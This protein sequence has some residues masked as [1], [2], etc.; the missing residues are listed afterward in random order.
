MM[1][2]VWKNVM[3]AG[4]AGF[5]AMSPVQAE[6]PATFGYSAVMAG[7]TDYMFR[8]VSFTQGEPMINA[9]VEFTYGIAYLALSAENINSGSP[10][11]IGYG[12]LGPWEQ[13]I[14]IGIRPTTGAIQW[15]IGLL[16]YIYG[17]RGGGVG[18]W[19][20]DFF[21]LK[22]GM[23][24]SPTENLTIGAT[25][26]YAP[27]Q[28]LAL[29]EGLTLQGDVSYKLKN[30]GVFTPTLSA[31]VGR[32]GLAENAHYVGGYFVDVDGDP[33]KSIVYW[34]A[35]LRLDVERLFFDFRYWDTNISSSDT[36]ARFVFSAGIDLSP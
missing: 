6:Q 19:D 31:T 15:D 27:E 1:M 36:D 9:Y 13:D 5:M 33:H 20:R 30:V 3:G 11:D 35:G 16:W 10:D 4:M 17:V 2:R 24:V 14:Y 21:E 25:S 23:S 12:A 32:W 34:N 18:V 29:P 28:G 26:F 7:A 22:L 8:G